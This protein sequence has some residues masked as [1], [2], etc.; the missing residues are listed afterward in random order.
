MHKKNQA[1]PHS[2]DKKTKLK[3]FCE[4]R[5]FRGIEHR[6]FSI[7]SNHSI[8]TSRITDAGINECIEHS[9]IRLKKSFYSQEYPTKTEGPV[10]NDASFTI[11]QKVST[12]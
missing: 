3:K 6:G 9:L 5:E 4:F 2:K 7:T 10:A 1:T 12:E 8:S 11:E